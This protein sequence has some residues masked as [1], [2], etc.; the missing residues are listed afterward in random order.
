LTVV[1]FDT[2]VLVCAELEPGTK[3]GVLA[4]SLVE[5]ASIGQGVIPAQV[6]GEFLAV[7]RRKRR[8]LFPGACELAL[9]FTS[10]FTIAETDVTVMRNAIELAQRHRLQFWDAVIYAASL[11]AGAT[12]LL[13]EVMHDKFTVG[14]LMIINPF[15][16]ANADLLDRIVPPT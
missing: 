3:K 9:E 5:R 4:G 6:L 8:E 1:A 16:E 11:K 10:L 7:V 14:G 15:D 13:S 12:Y 2:N